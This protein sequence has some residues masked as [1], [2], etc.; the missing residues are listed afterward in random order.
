[1]STGFYAPPLMT[2]LLSGTDIRLME[3]VSLGS[4]EVDFGRREIITREG[5]RFKDREAI[6]LKV[7]DNILNTDKDLRIV[8][9]ATH[10]GLVFSLV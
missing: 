7:P 8:G 6:I 9:G 2:K 1:M 10:Q 4:K 3:C 5:K